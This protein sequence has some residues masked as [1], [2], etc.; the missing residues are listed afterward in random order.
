VSF[1]GYSTAGIGTDSWE[2]GYFFL[3][4][5]LFT[6]VLVLPGYYFFLSRAVV[7]VTVAKV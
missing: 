7:E 1:I 3:L 6:D 4:G 5:Q 2:V